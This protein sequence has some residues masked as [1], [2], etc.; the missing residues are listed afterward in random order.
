MA[1]TNDQD[2]KG[3]KKDL[4]QEHTL[5]KENELRFEVEAGERVK[6][7]LMNGNAEVFGTELVRTRSYIFESSSKS[8]VYTWHGCTIKLT[9]KLEVAYV[10]K[11]TPMVLYL[12]THCAIETMRRKAEKEDTR[13][14]RVLIVGPQDVGK[15]ALTRILANYGIRM[16]RK[17]TLVDVDVGQGSVSIPGTMAAI[18]VE[19][20]ADPVSGFDS[21]YPLVYHFGHT[22]P[23]GNLKLY[24]VLI[25]RIA[26]VF[27]AKCECNPIIKASGCIINTCGWIKGQGYNSIL[28][29]SEQF[30][31]DAVLV[32]DNERLHNDLKRDLP[33]FVDIVLLPKSPGVVERSRE[34][35]RDYREDKIKEYFYG[36]NK[37]YFPH[38]YDIN[39][40]DICIYKIGAP[41]LPDSCLP[42][43]MEPEDSQTKLVPVKP[44]L[45]LVHHI[46]S[47]SMAES[48]EENLIE[49]NVAGFV[50]VTGVDPNR[51]TI[52]VLAPA[53]YPLPRKHFLIMDLRF[54]DIS[55]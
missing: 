42:L 38:L 17:P 41:E 46:L 13:G 30:Q 32:L 39:F 25:S 47:L 44:Q 37:S 11:E 36:P 3:I 20:H 45:D 16:G 19:R 50:V 52:S 29:V 33:D 2:E 22:S 49:T 12:N 34:L 48:L 14:P 5:M 18:A 43:G 9:G 8:A 51:E 10:S 35:R 24:Q 27:N 31:C 28:H 55:R 1:A 54:M 4:V 23:N 40:S 15:S 21:K 7:E 26:D 6:L 53:P